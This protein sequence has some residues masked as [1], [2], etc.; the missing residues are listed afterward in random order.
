MKFPIVPTDDIKNTDCCLSE[1]KQM[2]FPLRMVLLKTA[3]FYAF[4][5]VLA[6]S[7]GAVPGVR[8]P[9]VADVPEHTYLHAAAQPS[10]ATIHHGLRRQNDIS[11]HLAKI[12]IERKLQEETGSG[13][14]W[15]NWF[16]QDGEFTLNEI[17]IAVGLAIGGLI[18]L[19]CLGLCCCC[20]CC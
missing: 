11:I 13:L 8:A 4:L 19:C 1:T 2:Y 9:E 5:S 18:A 14:F 12:D 6:L 15:D 17:L 10:P 3:L 7:A 20:M 16:D